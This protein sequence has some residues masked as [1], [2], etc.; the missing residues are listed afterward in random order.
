MVRIAATA[1]LLVLGLCGGAWADIYSYTAPDG[2]VTLSNVPADD[3]YTVLVPSAQARAAAPL[4][5][6]R[7][8]SAAG[9]AGAY[10]D[11]IEQVA[12]A[13]GVDSALLHAVVSV[14]SRYNASAV[15]KKGAVGLMQLMP[16]TARR[17]GVAD[18]FDPLQN[19]QGGARYL[20]D[21]L[22]LFGNDLEL[23]IAAYNA[24][25]NAVL[26]HGN[27]V[28]PYDETRRYVPQVL[29]SYQR[30]QAAAGPA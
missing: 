5:A 6:P 13:S 25:E 23:A 18:A 14:E 30:L 4:P 9:N 17:Y 26:K 2:S 28:P 21:L 29:D 16:A 3:R 22:R 7:P 8:P 15:S 19:L 27:R 1:L 11:L 24:G 10:A 12:R 20:R